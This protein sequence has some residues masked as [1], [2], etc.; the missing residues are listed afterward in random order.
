MTTL[1]IG[2]NLKKALLDPRSF[3]WQHSANYG[4]QPIAFQDV[5]GRYL[6]CNRSFEN[7]SR[8]S[9]N[10]I[11]GKCNADIFDPDVSRS[12]EEGF[13]RARESNISVR[14]N[15]WQTF[16]H[17][18]CLY[19]NGKHIVVRDAS[20][21]VGFIS[22]FGDSTS[23]LHAEEIMHDTLHILR[24][25]L[26]NPL[27]ASLF[28]LQEKV[29]PACRDPNLA[30]QLDSLQRLCNEAKELIHVCFQFQEENRLAAPLPGEWL[31][32]GELAKQ[33]AQ[34]VQAEWGP[35]F[36]ISFDLRKASDY[37]WSRAHALDCGLAG[38]RIFLDT[39]RVP[40]DTPLSLNLVMSSSVEGHRFSLEFPVVPIDAQAVDIQL[41]TRME[42]LMAISKSIRVSFTIQ[43]DSI[44]FSLHLPRVEPV[45]RSTSVVPAPPN[46]I[47]DYEGEAFG[48]IHSFYQAR[49]DL[50]RECRAVLS[51]DNRIQM[52]SLKFAELFQCPP[53]HLYHRH[54]REF[55]SPSLA[56]VLDALLAR[57]DGT[58][59][60]QATKTVLWI[61]QVIA[62]C[63]VV[64]SVA[65][66]GGRI[67][68]IYR[69]PTEY[70]VYM[71][72]HLQDAFERIQTR[73][74][75]MQSIY[76]DL[77]VAPFP[78]SRLQNDLQWMSQANRDML[79]L[80]TTWGLAE[81]IDAGKYPYRPR[82]LDLGKL[83][84][85]VEEDARRRE[86]PV[87]FARTQMAPGTHLIL[88]DASLLKSLFF[89]LLKNACQASRAND[90]TLAVH[91][92]PGQV[93]ITIRNDGEVPS[94]IRDT[95]FDKMVKGPQSSGMGIGTYSAKLAV[96]L[97]GGTLALDTAEP[98]FTTLTILLPSPPPSPV[99]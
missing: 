19:V 18:P 42:F 88:G 62:W 60:Y 95:F 10:D 13:I 17:G 53:E 80:V 35:L 46:V 70:W 43:P 7:M 50:L 30:T 2:P 79:D 16:G 9:L 34:R 8:Q 71:E 56:K 78:D 11:I 28:Y 75:R 72:W 63:V 92:A 32:P 57:K 99:I 51:D 52:C 73:L 66:E 37:L 40:P 97:H 98:G 74:D 41:A 20:G 61:D 96:E 14:C 76:S 54:Y 4:L 82:P 64:I 49:A 55:A 24:H 36:R 67:L 89:N 93:R 22:I 5:H 59:G 39:A 23:R 77:L 27:S 65:K 48:G 91:P 68:H 44:C 3:F 90:I 86:Y 69:M 25:D 29:R 26:Q 45:P 6:A 47:Q 31:S 33:L 85:Q 87:V 12:L 94:S 1:T 21:P 81:A 83:L 58:V 84:D 38:I 15:F